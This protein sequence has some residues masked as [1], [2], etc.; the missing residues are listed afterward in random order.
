MKPLKH[1]ICLSLGSLS[2]FADQRTLPEGEFEGFF[3]SKEKANLDF[4]FDLFS[5]VRSLCIKKRGDGLSHTFKKAKHK[6]K[7][8]DI[9]FRE[10]WQAHG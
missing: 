9:S 4:F 2:F 8:K 6:Q 10:H 3:L 5:V 1:H 7:K